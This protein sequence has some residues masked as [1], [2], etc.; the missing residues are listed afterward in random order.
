MPT[1]LRTLTLQGARDQ[2]LQR[3]RCA[4]ASAWP[5]AAASV[6]L[7]TEWV[8]V[9]AGP[10]ETAA[11]PTSLADVHAA[12]AAA[13]PLPCGSRVTYEP[14]GQLELSGPPCLGVSE[15][16]NGMATDLTAIDAGLARYGLRRLG[17]GIDPHRPPCRVVDTP[18]Y[19]AMEAFFNDDGEFGRTMMCSTASVQV[20]VGG[21]NEATTERRARRAHV[22]GPPLVAAFANS[23]VAGGRPTG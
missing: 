12:V 9:G 6:G 1:P 2:I 10:D 3:C 17:S 23:P 16:M 18:R 21:D 11:R 14:G 20:N 7:E 19:R 4:P 8:I 5:G 13:G 15:A 22:F